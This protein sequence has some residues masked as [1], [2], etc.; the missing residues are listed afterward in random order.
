MAEDPVGRRTVLR[1]A[2][3][4]GGAGL[5]STLAA[6][7][8]GPR[9]PS[10]ATA[11]PGVQSPRAQPSASSGTSA[12]RVLMAYFSRAGENYW[13][14]GRRVLQTGNTQVVAETIAELV[15]LEVHRIEAADPYPFEYEPTVQRSWSEVRT[16]ARP[17][18]AHPSPAA[19]AFDVILLGSPV[20]A[21]QEPMIMRTFVE[22]LDGL[23]GKQVYPFVTYA[24][25]GFGSVLDHYAELC[26]DASIGDG[27]AVRGEE[28][29]S[30]EAEIRTWLEGNGLL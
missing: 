3:A 15:D 9:P 12:P 2:I 27:L 26:P 20:W 11:S 13:Y 14:G 30:A 8:T 6:C 25:S 18:I 23:A 19:D 5:A 16:E 1:A 4:I 21:S 24:V 7:T 10:P 29:T 17:G 22:G 28:A